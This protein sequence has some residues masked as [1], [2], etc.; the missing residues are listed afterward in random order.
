LCAITLLTDVFYE[1]LH[2]SI[3][4]VG[5]NVF[6]LEPLVRARK[7]ADPLRKTKKIPLL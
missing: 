4:Q 5:V 2:K 7:P 3:A 1:E 6:V